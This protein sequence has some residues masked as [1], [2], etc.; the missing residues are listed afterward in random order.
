MCPKFITLGKV[1]AFSVAFCFSL[2]AFA[3]TQDDALTIRTD[4][5]GT[6]TV[7][8][9]DTLWDI[10]GRF[11]DKPWRW[12]EIWNMNRDQVKYP[13]L[14]YP[15][16]VINLSFIDGKA[17]LTIER[18]SPAVRASVLPHEAIPSIPPGDIE[19][20][21]TRSFIAEQQAL[22][23]APVIIEGRDRERFLRANN[24]LVYVA[25]LDANK[26]TRWNIFRP[27]QA[28]RD[29]RGNIIGTEYRYLGTAEVERFGSHEN[30][31]STVRI[32]SVRE[33]IGVGDRLIPMPKETMVHYAPHAP[34][35]S[36]E[37]YIV[38]SQHGGA[39]MGR[40]DIITLDQGT[41]QG[42][43][44]GHVLAVYRQMAPIPDP[45]PNT[46][47][48]QII[49]GFD[50]TTF[51]LKPNMIE[52]PDERIGLVFVF[53]AFDNASYGML[54]NMTYPAKVG[55]AVRNP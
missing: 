15:G 25:G 7:K 29:I 16:D 4:A 41:R 24:D 54:L 10:A 37:A 53:R 45:R 30:E 17:R 36:I 1:A 42:V 39:E 38:N 23:K 21:L 52:V 14:I 12:P 28:V 2:G 48:E 49:K 55:D 5:P 13:H 27:G 33:E 19:P 34:D 9:G 46:G 11:L 47:Q 22:S 3:Q 51:Y 20:F 26:G 8:K 40:T 31:A 44:V 6:Y 35:Q 50:Q 43:E 18:L 32:V